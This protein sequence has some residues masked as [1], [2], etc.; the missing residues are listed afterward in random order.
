MNLPSA[1]FTGPLD[2]SKAAVVE[3]SGGNLGQWYRIGEPQQSICSSREN[4]PPFCRKEWWLEMWTII[5]NLSSILGFLGLVVASVW[6]GDVSDF[7]GLGK[8]PST[9]EIATVAPTLSSTSFFFSCLSAIFML[10]GTNTFTILAGCCSHSA[11]F[12]RI[13]LSSP[14]FC[15]A[16]FICIFFFSFL[17]FVLFP[18]CSVQYCSVLFHS[19]LFASFCS[20]LFSSLLFFYFSLL[21]NSAVL[22]SLLLWSILFCSDSF[23]LLFLYSLFECECVDMIS[24][25]PGKSLRGLQG[26]C[27]YC[28][29]SSALFSRDLHSSVAKAARKELFGEC[30]DAIASLSSCLFEQKCAAV[31]VFIPLTVSLRPLLS[32]SLEFDFSSISLES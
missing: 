12:S 19:F 7:C 26:P 17:Q 30:L 24:R 6:A 21:F 13:R 25:S 5:L 8:S 3:F 23:K 16:V 31:P 15:C 29:E 9:C 28:G 32:L 18:S 20:L 4:R 2:R 22:L 27:F 10:K 14:L 11:L 1:M